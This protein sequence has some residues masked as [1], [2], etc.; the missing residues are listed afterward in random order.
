MREVSKIIAGKTLEAAIRSGYGYEGA[1]HIIEDVILGVVATC[2]RTPSSSLYGADFRAV[3]DRMVENALSKY[4]N[5]PMDPA[6]AVRKDAVP[7]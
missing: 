6:E 5:A 7:N 3:A 2:I 1:L 4:K